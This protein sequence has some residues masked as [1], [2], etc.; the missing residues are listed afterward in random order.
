MTP[1]GTTR[2]GLP[3][4]TQAAAESA[5]RATRAGVRSVLAENAIA[6][7]GA[8]TRCQQTI[9]ENWCGCGACADCCTAKFAEG[10]ISAFEACAALLEHLALDRD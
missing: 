4:V 9:A 7:R 2:D 10:Q 3:V 5:V 6:L 8:A 1:V